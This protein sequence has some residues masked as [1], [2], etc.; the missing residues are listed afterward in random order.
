MLTRDQMNEQGM[1][2]L[3]D[4]LGY[5]AGMRSDTYSIDGRTD[6]GLINFLKEHKTF[7]ITSTLSA[8]NGR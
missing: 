6:S 2:N 8:N 3:Q 4:A 1:G 7:L 5:A